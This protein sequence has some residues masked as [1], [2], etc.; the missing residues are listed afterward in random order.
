M[1]FGLSNGADGQHG[2]YI[3]VSCMMDNMLSRLRNANLKQNPKSYLGH[4]ITRSG[5]QTD[6]SK[7]GAVDKWPVP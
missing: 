1:P 6:S 7:T 3:L 5:I 4:T 2:W